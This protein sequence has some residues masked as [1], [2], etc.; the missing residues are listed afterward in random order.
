MEYEKNGNDSQETQTKYTHT[1][2][3]P[4]PACTALC[5]PAGSIALGR[6]FHLQNQPSNWKSWKCDSSDQVIQFQSSTDQWQYSLEQ[7][8]CSNWL[9]ASI[10]I[11]WQ[12]QN[13][14][15][16]SVHCTVHW[17]IGC[18]APVLNWDV[19]WSS[20]PLHC[21][22]SDFVSWSGFH[23]CITYVCTQLSSEIDIYLEFAYSLIFLT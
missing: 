10:M 3:E 17:L 22:I 2:I 21:V 1:V 6:L 16:Y 23:F 4:Q 5:Y 15:Q 7:L 11:S 13:T 20:V 8:R 12:L 14:I 18:V 19:S 9:Q